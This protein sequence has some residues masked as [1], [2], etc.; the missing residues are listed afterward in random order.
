ME[1]MSQEITF[2]L[3]PQAYYHSLG[4][5]ADYVPS[6]FAREGFIHC[7]DAP[8]EMARVANAYYGSNPNPHYYV[9]IDKR[10]VHAPIRYDDEA[11]LYPHIY[12]PLNRD[13]IVAIRPAARA[14]DGTF[15]SPEPVEN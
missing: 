6:E 1:T 9:Y 7:T 3:V 5:E 11:H 8:A 14:A 13:A 2:H 10:R 4:A 15:L 12:G